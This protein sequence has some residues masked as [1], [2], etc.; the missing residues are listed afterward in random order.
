MR[1]EDLRPVQLAVLGRVRMEQSGVP[2]PHPLPP[3]LAAAVARGDWLFHPEALNRLEREILRLAAQPGG[4]QRSELS[5]KLGLEADALAPVLEALRAQGRL[6]PRGGILFPPADPRHGLSP[7]A[8]RLLDD[9][10]QAGTEG[11]EP[12]RL[13]VAGAQKELATLA[14]TGLAVSLDGA[15]Y[16]AAETYLAQV[17]AI[18]AGR[19]AGELLELD[20]A[21]AA[22]GL[23]RKY[24]IP[25]LNRMEGDGY[26]KREGDARRVRRLPE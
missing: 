8:R 6:V 11:L 13:K 19:A 9:L 18:L 1:P 20:Q 24:L 25:L 21:K 23:S 10:I 2:A 15:I 14:R 16:Y 17:R 26:V 5:G 12:K 3:G 7:L 4:V 22:S